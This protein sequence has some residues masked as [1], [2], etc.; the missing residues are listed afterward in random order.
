MKKIYESVAFGIVAVHELKE[1]IRDE[2]SDEKREALESVRFAY[3]YLIDNICKQFG[4]TRINV[5]EALVEN[6]YDHH[7]AVE[8][9]DSYEDWAQHVVKSNERGDNT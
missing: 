2:C 4:C 7:Q 8:I 9:L 3:Y 1:M 5:A 6:G